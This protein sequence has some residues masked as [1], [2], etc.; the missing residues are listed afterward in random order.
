[1][2]H[3]VFTLRTQKGAWREWE[4]QESGQKDYSF[5][6]MIPYKDASKLDILIN[7]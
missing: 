1:M 4:R 3:S 6:K 5:Y 2:E 7:A